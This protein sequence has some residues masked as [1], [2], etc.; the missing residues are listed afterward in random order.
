MENAAFEHFATKS[1][2]ALQRHAIAPSLKR[3]ANIS[4]VS[5]T[6]I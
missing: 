6:M 4:R 2:S 3:G 5:T 1:P